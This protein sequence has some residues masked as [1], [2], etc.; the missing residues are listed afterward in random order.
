M[1]TMHF[2]RLLIIITVFLLFSCQKKNFDLINSSE[3]QTIGKQYE[4][5]IQQ[6]KDLLFKFKG[7]AEAGQIIKQEYA[8]E[9]NRTLIPVGEII[10]ERLTVYRYILTGDN[11]EQY[12]ISSQPINENDDLSVISITGEKTIV[13]YDNLVSNGQNNITINPKIAA[14]K[15]TNGNTVE[16]VLPPDECSGP[17][18]CID[19]YFTTWDTSTGEIISEVYLYTTCSCSPA[20]GS[21]A[22][23]DGTPIDS[24]VEL[25]PF[26]SSSFDE[27]DFDAPQA[28][29]IIYTHNATR[30]LQRGVLINVI[31]DP[32][33]A[34]PMHSVYFDRSGRQVTRKLTLYG[35]TN[36]W[37][38]LTT[39]SA[40]VNWSWITH[41]LIQYS[42]G[43][44]NWATIK[45]LTASRV[46]N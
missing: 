34:T 1:K 27:A 43:D 21:G 16:K 3:E 46:I 12:V 37:E 23:G 6:H 9:T 17:Q 8:S 14:K 26:S 2:S 33:T 30:V 45:P 38:R 10:S 36:Y 18:I 4:D 20:G 41:Y 39:T 5:L 25:V 29:K 7:Q 13:V 22:G 44:P 31:I 28:P 32:T 42:N 19:W 24:D 40:K 11:R 35:H 15:S